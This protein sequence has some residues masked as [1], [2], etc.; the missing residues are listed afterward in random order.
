[1]K[2]ISVVAAAVAAD[3]STRTIRRWL[4]EGRLK[5]YERAGRIRIWVDADDL[6]RFIK[7]KAILP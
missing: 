2:P 1:L 5:R 3:V 7:P 6:K 4:D